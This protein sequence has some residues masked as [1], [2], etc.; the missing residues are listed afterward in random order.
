MNGLKL[1]TVRMIK[2]FML[3]EF[4]LHNKRDCIKFR[5]CLEVLLSIFDEHFTVNHIQ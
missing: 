1:Y 5:R 3:L 2:V 4:Q